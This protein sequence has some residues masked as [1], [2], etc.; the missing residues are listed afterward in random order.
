M[1]DP[2][3]IAS[4]RLRCFPGRPG[5]H[6]RHSTWK[7][8]ESLR[9]PR[10]WGQGLGQGADGIF[11]RK[12]RSDI[13]KNIPSGQWFQHVPDISQLAKSSSK[14]V[15][16][17]IQ[18]Q[19]ETCDVYRQF[20]M[21]HPQKKNN[22]QC[23][24]KIMFGIFFRVHVKCTR[25]DKRVTWAVP[26]A[27]S[28]C[29]RLPCQTCVPKQAKHDQGWLFCAA[30]WQVVNIKEEE[31]KYG[32]DLRILVFEQVSCRDAN[33]PFWS[34]ISC[35]FSSLRGIQDTNHPSGIGVEPC[36]MWWGYIN[37][38]TG[39]DLDPKNREGR[40][41]KEGG[42]QKKVQTEASWIILVWME[43]FY[44]LH[45]DSNKGEP[46]PSRWIALSWA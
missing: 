9:L 6:L 36:P 44:R 2:H 25:P 38:Q 7:G 42:K 1:W 22:I 3:A 19:D 17:I 30:T 10:R 34:A 35:D 45:K 15:Q 46:Y 5:S 21:G 16:H 12:K 32:L 43:R 4:E 40:F 31:G 20:N 24:S 13:K 8:G 14:R 27:G 18:Q 29:P 33:L 11:F 28:Q 26:C 37:Q 23:S 39:Q 41:P